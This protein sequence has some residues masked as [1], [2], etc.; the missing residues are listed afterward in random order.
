MS[1]HDFWWYNSGSEW[2]WNLDDRFRFIILDLK[3]QQLEIL[4]NQTIYKNGTLFQKL[5]QP[6]TM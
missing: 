3:K 6:N 1:D 2:G 4:R 5:Y